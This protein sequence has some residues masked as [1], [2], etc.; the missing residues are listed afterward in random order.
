[1]YFEL[2]GFTKYLLDGASRFEQQINNFFCLPHS[3]RIFRFVFRF[4]TRNISSYLGLGICAS[5]S[6][7]FACYTTTGFTAAS[8]TSRI[9]ASTLVLV[10]LVAIEQLLSFT[11][12]L[13]SKIFVPLLAAAGALFLIGILFLALLKRH[14][15]SMPNQGAANRR[16]TFRRA[17]NLCLWAS[18]AFALASAFATAQ[19]TS[20][21]QYTTGST[22]SS[23]HVTTG[24]T[25]QV[26]QWLTFAFS[27]TFAFGIASMFQSANADSKDSGDP[28]MDFYP[29]P[30]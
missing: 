18:T 15:K 8:L 3:G 17:T 7:D 1:M 25:L 21:L 16:Q 20:A 23:I 29:P 14:I 13:Q 26:L 27:V 10:D 12:F 22:Q 6:K 24:V 5:T 4:G 28:S 30:P 9:N 2:P 11:I 19:T